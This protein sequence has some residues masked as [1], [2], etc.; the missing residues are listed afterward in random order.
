MR[1]TVSIQKTLT[2]S[3]RLALSG[4]NVRC[5]YAFPTT[6]W[7]VEID[8]GQIGQVFHNVLINADQ[9]MPEG[10][11]IKVLVENRGVGKEDALPV[12]EG[13]YVR[14]SM[15]DQGTGIPE[16][17]LQK[18]FD[19][20]FTTKDRGNGLGLSTSFA[21]VHRHEGTIQ[22][23][24]TMGVGTTFHVYL[25]ASEKEPSAEAGDR[26]TLVRGRGR[27]L[28]V[29]DDAVVRK[30]ARSILEHLG[31][32]VEQALD[33]QECLNRY[34]DAMESGKPFRY[35]IIDLTIPGGMG[36]KQAIKDLRALNPGAVVIV[37]SGYSDDPIMSDYE[38]HGFD[39][40]AP[41]PYTV[42][43]LSK[44]LRSLE[45]REGKP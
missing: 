11:T 19:P 36:G 7:H 26:R 15:E 6:L 38:A 29:D 31:Y 27:I 4:S 45:E 42:E 43:D 10:G 34:Q 41:K 23:E 13:R 35:V 20:F 24:S 33:G 5:E 40:V 22:V 18:V 30:A 28:V 8:E 32:E 12:R 9:S 39:G 16:K 37:S 3:V 2:D 25:P 44:L 1:K 17:H 21:I 14:V